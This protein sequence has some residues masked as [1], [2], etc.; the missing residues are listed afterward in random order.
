M[1]K[2]SP[3]LRLSA[4]PRSSSTSRSTIDR[5]VDQTGNR[6]AC[7][8]LLAQHGDRHA[9]YRELVNAVEDVDGL[10]L[11]ALAIKVARIGFGRPEPGLGRG[12][13]GR[14]VVERGVVHFHCLVI[15]PGLLGNQRAVIGGEDGVPFGALQGLQVFQ[16]VGRVARAGLGPPGHQPGD[17]PIEVGLD[18]ELQQVFSAGVVLLAERIDGK[19]KPRE[20]L[21]VRHRL[22]LVG[23]RQPLVEIAIRD[24]REK[25]A[26]LQ[27]GIVGIEGQRALVVGDGAWHVIVDLGHAG[28]EE[29]A[30]ER[31]NV[32]RLVRLLGQRRIACKRHADHRREPREPSVTSKLHRNP[33]WA[34]PRT[35][36]DSSPLWPQSMAF[37]GLAFNH[38]PFTI[39]SLGRRPR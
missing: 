22:Q 23:P 27:R 29:R 2:I 32:D 37:L 9:P 35:R 21:D 6:L 20:A 3:P 28:S 33:S 30:R 14:D 5:P 19:H 4:V 1:T 12:A 8:D 13:A 7:L 10:F 17:Q 16:R 26:L 15:E 24:Q 34:P 18:G 11:L 25:Q 38:A 36:R 39:R 31:A